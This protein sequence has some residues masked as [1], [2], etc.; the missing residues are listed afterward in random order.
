MELAPRSSTPLVTTVQGF[1]AGAGPPRGRGQRQQPWT[2]RIA[3][4][5][6]AAVMPAPLSG[7]PCIA[8]IAAAH[9]QPAPC[10]IAAEPQTATARGITERDRSAQSGSPRSPDL[11]V[12]TRRADQQRDPALDR[13][14]GDD[15]CPCGTD[16][17]PRSRARPLRTLLRRLCS[18]Q[19]LGH[20]SRGCACAPARRLI[21]SGTARPSGG[22]GDARSSYR[23]R[24]AAATH[25]DQALVIGYLRILRGR[26]DQPTPP[27]DLRTTE[28]HLSLRRVATQGNTFG[29]RCYI[30]PP[31]RYD[32]SDAG[33]PASFS[34]SPE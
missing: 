10:W 13:H 24:P 6:A 30:C 3:A 21:S 25:L 28:H 32:P 16:E 1:R 2:A 20:H 22:T 18:G 33:L 4:T 23:P 5:T 27:A 26:A 9:C 29:R 15:R 34:S 8:S 31:D 12:L 19:I 7:A 11:V 14:S 17:C